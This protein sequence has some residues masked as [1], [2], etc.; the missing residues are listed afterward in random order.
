MSHDVRDP[1]RAVDC[2]RR[3][4]DLSGD[5]DPRILDILAAAYAAAGRFE[6]A[7]TTAQR[8]LGAASS[9]QWS[10]KAEG[11][12]KR[13]KLYRARTAPIDGSLQ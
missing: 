2:A 8:A 1:K 5:G 6:L 12:R 10:Q 7:V 11:I 4:A 9:P 13:L 3:A